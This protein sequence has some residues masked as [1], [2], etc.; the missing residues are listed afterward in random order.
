M[1]QESRHMYVHL[2]QQV[3]KN[4]NNIL[5]TWYIPSQIFTVN[6]FQGA[7][8]KK[9]ITSALINDLMNGTCIYVY[10][11]IITL[12]NLPKYYESC[13]KLTCS[14]LYQSR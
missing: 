10:M 2:I 11:I 1:H 13:L 8:R 4:C 7:Q 6:F 5:G 9:S 3:E 12:K 14:F